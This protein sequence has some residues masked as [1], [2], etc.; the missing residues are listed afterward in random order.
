[1]SNNGPQ[2]TISDPSSLS[3][4][5]NKW[6]DIVKHLSETEDPMENGDSFDARNPQH[7]ANR[8]KFKFW[9]PMTE[10]EFF[11]SKRSQNTIV[12]KVDIGGPTTNLGSS[13]STSGGTQSEKKI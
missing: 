13:G 11:A 1:M 3:D 12:H 9:K 5:Y 2:R 7:V 8:M 6:D 10:E 4:Y